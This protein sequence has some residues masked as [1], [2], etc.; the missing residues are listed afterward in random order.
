MVTRTSGVQTDINTNYYT[1]INLGFFRIDIL[2]VDLT[3]DAGVV[4]GASELIIQTLKPRAYR[5]K[6]QGGHTHIFVIL[7]GADA[8]STSEVQRRIRE[9]GDSVGPNNRDLTG[10]TVTVKNIE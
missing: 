3:N 5:I 6:P 4:G 2:G 7:E 1:D 10:A 8:D 9:L